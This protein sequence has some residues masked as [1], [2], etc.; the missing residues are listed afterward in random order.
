MTRIDDQAV[1]RAA[2]AQD[3]VVLVDVRP[4]DQVVR[5]V[6]VARAWP[7]HSSGSTAVAGPDPA[8]LAAAV[9]CGPERTAAQDIGFGLRQITDVA[10]K[11]L[12]PGINDPTTAVHAIGHLA[13]LLCDLADRD[14]GPR[15]VLDDDELVRL[16][17][18]RP[19]YAEL[20]EAA[21]QQPRRYGAGDPQVV[22]QLYR[23]LEALAHRVP[24]QLRPVVADQLRRLGDTVSAQ[25][26]D[27]VERRLLR[28]LESRVDALLT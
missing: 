18:T 7:R 26:F 27:D 23:L 13:A 14:L 2:V 3:L 5:G 17:L 24:G 28:D 6:P 19:T 12:S 21:I 25:D 4:G 20:V 22:A 1:L 16:V 8:P 9:H 11:S 10:T 15:A